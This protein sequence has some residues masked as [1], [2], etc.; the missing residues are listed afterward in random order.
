MAYTMAWVFDEYPS[1]AMIAELF[2]DAVN[3]QDDPHYQSDFYYGVDRYGRP[4]HKMYMN[5]MDN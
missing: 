1:Q 5:D 4:I 2:F 3:L